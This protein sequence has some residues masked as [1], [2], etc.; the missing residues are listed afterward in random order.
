LWIVEKK[1][2]RFFI[3]AGLKDSFTD[4]LQQEELK[5][6]QALLNRIVL[7]QRADS[8]EE[9]GVGDGID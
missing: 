1:G 5:K 7:A 4:Y 8:I 2:N 6:K 3:P 9:D